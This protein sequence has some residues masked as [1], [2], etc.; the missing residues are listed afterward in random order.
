MSCM[1]SA[2]KT[3]SLTVRSGKHADAIDITDRVQ[4]VVRDSGVQSGLCHVYVPHWMWCW[5]NAGVNNT[6]GDR[7]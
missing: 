6:S 3:D 1:A 4:A 5:V 2:A 7:S